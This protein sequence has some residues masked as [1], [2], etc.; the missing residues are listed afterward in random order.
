MFFATLRHR[1]LLTCQQ[2][3]RQLFASRA[4]TCR[5]REPPSAPPQKQAK[6][7][8]LTAATLSTSACRHETQ[9]LACF[10][11]GQAGHFAREC[12]APVEAMKHA[13]WLST[14]KGE[15][16]QRK[17]SVA[18]HSFSVASHSLLQLRSGRPS[19][20]RLQSRTGR[21]TL[22]LLPSGRTHRHRLSR[23]KGGACHTIE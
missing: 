12:T 5:R 15:I 2:S 17:F 23:E 18:S 9:Q 21:R 19:S 8:A 22:L 11:C 7:I 10:R 14:V 13:G 3:L 1:T 4:V 6:M 16:A 20:A